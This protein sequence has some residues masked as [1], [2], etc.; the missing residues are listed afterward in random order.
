MTSGDL[1][2]FS[3]WRGLTMKEI[4]MFFH[5]KE[6]DSKIPVTTSYLKGILSFVLVVVISLYLPQLKISLLW[7]YCDVFCSNYV[8]LNSHFNVFWFF[9]RKIYCLWMLKYGTLMLIGDW[10]NLFILRFLRDAS[11]LMRDFCKVSQCERLYKSLSK[12]YW[13]T[14]VN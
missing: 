6:C 13:E 10:E 11:L 9:T 8:T 7:S 14:S 12:T 1:K 5:I 4:K 3:F 2:M